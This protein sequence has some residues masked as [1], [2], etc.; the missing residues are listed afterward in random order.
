MENYKNFYI[1]YVQKS[2]FPNFFPFKVS[3]FFLDF[4]PNFLITFLLTNSFK[5]L[6]YTAASMVLA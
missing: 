1:L 6:N 2:I 4:L 3:Q 5:I